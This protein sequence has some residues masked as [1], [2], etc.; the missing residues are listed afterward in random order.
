MEQIEEEE[1]E[2]WEEGRSKVR[3]QG[4]QAW[5]GVQGVRERGRL[6]WP[7]WCREEDQRWGEVDGERSEG[8]EGNEEEATQRV[9][10]QEQVSEERRSGQE[11][12][13]LNVVLSQVV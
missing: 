11:R 3:R 5:V 6:G 2:V 12:C 8:E 7:G 10:V 9:A 1:E 4:E 13:L